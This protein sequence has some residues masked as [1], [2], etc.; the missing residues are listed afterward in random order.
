WPQLQARSIE[1]RF[2]KRVQG[3]GFD[4]SGVH[5]YF[6]S[7]KCPR[8]GCDQFLVPCGKRSKFCPGCRMYVDRDVVGSE[9]IGTICQAQIT[10]QRRPAKFMPH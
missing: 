5:E 6:T 10:D 7:A 4:V 3:M 9:N 8:R 2:I 1:M